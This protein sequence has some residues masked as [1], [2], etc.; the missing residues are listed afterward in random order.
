M[1]IYIYKVTSPSN[2]HYI[3]ISNNFNKRRND[4]QKDALKKIKKRDVELYKQLTYHMIPKKH[5]S[6]T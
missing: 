5:G 6:K 2:K 1:I 3:G 4:H